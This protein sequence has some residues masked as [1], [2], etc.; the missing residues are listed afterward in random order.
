[1]SAPVTAAMTMWQP[2][3]AAAK[4]A[5]VV[6]LVV[7]EET[8]RQN[9]RFIV[10]EALEIEQPTCVHVMPLCVSVK[11]VGCAAAA[12]SNTTTVMR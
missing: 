1:M 7:P 5:V 12:A 8:A 11:D 2:S 6:V 10:R 3:I 4:F 9:D